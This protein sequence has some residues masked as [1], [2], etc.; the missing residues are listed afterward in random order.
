M[1]LNLG[2]GVL[3]TM[4]KSHENQELNNKYIYKMDSVLEMFS[5]LPFPMEDRKRKQSWVSLLISG[6]VICRYV[7]LL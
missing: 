1:Q 2:M 7:G 3:N 5:E 6:G 4:N